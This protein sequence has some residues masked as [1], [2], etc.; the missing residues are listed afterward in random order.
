LYWYNHNW[1]LTTTKNITSQILGG[2]DS[3][4][5]SIYTLLPIEHKGLVT[6][7]VIAY[8]SNGNDS[9]FLWFSQINPDDGSINW[10]Q[11]MPNTAGITLM[12]ASEHSIYA[13]GALRLSQTGIRLYRIN[14]NPFSYTS[15]FIT[16]TNPVQQPVSS[17]MQLYPNPSGDVFNLASEQG[18]VSFQLYGLDGRLVQTETVGA[19]HYTLRIPIAGVYLLSVQLQDGSITTQKVVKW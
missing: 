15:Q 16:S 18:I 14:V 8:R 5:T 12:A 9:S 19:T 17:V 4:S 3:L 1:N 2:Y 13:V 6:S 10:E 11:L 7:G